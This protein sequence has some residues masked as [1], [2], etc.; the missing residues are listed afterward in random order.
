M[1]GPELR[2]H[3]ER[4]GL[5]RPA[6]LERIGVRYSVQRLAD[7]EASSRP[8]PSELAE[9][10]AVVPPEG[11]ERVPRRAARQAASVRRAP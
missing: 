10:V 2:R 5:S 6:F 1:T 9:A 4:A 8:V 11:A 3:R 7:I